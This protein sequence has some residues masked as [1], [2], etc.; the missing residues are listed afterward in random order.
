MERSTWARVGSVYHVLAVDVA[1][2][3]IWFRIMGDE[4]TP[5]L[6]EAEMFEIVTSAIPPTWVAASPK[7]GRLSFEPE[8]WS[9]EGF[10][11]RFFDGEPRAVAAFEEERAKIIAADP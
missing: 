11:E 9:G 2:G 6:F 7:A 1:P 8:A 4:P 10:W 3:R 5:A